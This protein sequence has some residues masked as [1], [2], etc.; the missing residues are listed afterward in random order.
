LDSTLENI[1]T[2]EL[3]V[4]EMDWIRIRHRST[5]LH[6]DLKIRIKKFFS[7]AAVSL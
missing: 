6:Y 5:T 2:V 4:V 7:L 1:V 3:F